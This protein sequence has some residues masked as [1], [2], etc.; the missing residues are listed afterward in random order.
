MCWEMMEG[1]RYKSTETTAWSHTCSVATEGNIFRELVSLKQQPLEVFAQFFSTDL[2]CAFWVLNVITLWEVEFVYGRLGETGRRGK[3][4][5]SGSDDSKN[6]GKL[7]LWLWYANSSPKLSFG[8]VSKFR[9]APKKTAG[10]LQKE[11]K[12]EENDKMNT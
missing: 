2:V 1:R 10:I 5:R 11:R 7:Q 12:R 9:A 4:R 6:G 3:L 8:D